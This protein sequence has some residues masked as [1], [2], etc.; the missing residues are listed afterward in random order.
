MDQ[1]GGATIYIYI[2]TEVY[3]SLS[4]SLSP[5]LEAW[6]LGFQLPLLG[7]GIEG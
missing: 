4:L 2:Y 3:V 1:W 6:A 5:G 7:Q